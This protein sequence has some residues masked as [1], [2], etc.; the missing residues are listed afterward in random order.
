MRSIRL[1]GCFG[2]ER[3]GAGW[4]TITGH[5][6]QFITRRITFARNHRH[7]PRCRRQP[8]TIKSAPIATA[9]ASICDAALPSPMMRSVCSSGASLL[10][11]SSFMRAATDSMRRRWRH[12][13][14]RSRN[15]TGSS[16]T[17]SSAR[18]A[19][20][21]TARDRA[22]RRAPRDSWEKSTGT[23]IFLACHGL[24]GRGTLSSTCHG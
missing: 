24:T 4:I 17:V 13:E 3:G 6:A 7:H 5:G 16:M 2:A 22:W 20:S 1:S 11:A 10:P 14:W 8:M 21:L 9:V 19:P 18:C 12:G 23:S 15:D